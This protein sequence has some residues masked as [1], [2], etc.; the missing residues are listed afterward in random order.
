MPWA[1]RGERCHFHKAG[2]TQTLATEGTQPSTA[3]PHAS[4]APSPH[5][6][7]HPLVHSPQHGVQC[8]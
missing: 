8:T 2:S 1:G 6:L 4:T 3:R 5:L 7:R